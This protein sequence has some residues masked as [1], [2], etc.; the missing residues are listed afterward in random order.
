MCR[1]VTRITS[2]TVIAAILLTCTT[3]VA[4]TSTPPEDDDDFWFEDEPTSDDVNEG[5]LTF[6]QPPID[7]NVLH[8]V[9]RIR[10]STRSLH[11]GWINLEQCYHN[12]DP[13]SKVEV[14]YQYRDMRNLE[15]VSTENIGKA[16]IAENSVQ[17]ED[18]KKNATLCIKA[19]TRNFYRDRDR[20]F[21]LKNGPFM[22]IIKLFIRRGRFRTRTF[23]CYR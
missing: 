1:K 18:V 14:V 10:L 15:I 4:T 23:K 6:L 2:V 20:N 16:Q 8:S 5:T 12:L 22:V 21:I 7:P 11:T 13:I 3:V 17:L 19:E 9:N